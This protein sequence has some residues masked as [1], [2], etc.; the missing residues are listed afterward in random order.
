MEARSLYK[1]KY[2]DIWV[3]AEP[4]KDSFFKTFRLGLTDDQRSKVDARIEFIGNTKP[5]IKNENVS[6]KIE[7]RL[8]ELKAD[9]GGWFIRVFFFYHDRKL[10]IIH[11]FQKQGNKTPK[12]QIKRARDLRDRFLSS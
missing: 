7:E 9:S 10:I 4:G 3:L 8:F 11:G 1:G 2:L 6:K 5:P 12:E